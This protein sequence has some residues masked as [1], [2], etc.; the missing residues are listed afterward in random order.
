MARWCNGAGRG[1]PGCAQRPAPLHWGSA[2]VGIGRWWQIAE[3]A[4]RSDGVVQ[5]GLGTPTVP[6][7]G[8]WCTSGIR[9]PVVGSP[10]M[11]QSKDPVELFSGVI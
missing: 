7:F 10:F 2:A 5:Q 11:K 3:A 9:G 6:S 4:M 8:S 1:A